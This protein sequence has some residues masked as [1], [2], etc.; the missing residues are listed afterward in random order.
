MGTRAVY[1]FKDSVDSTDRFCVYKH[2]E[3]YPSDSAASLVSA[4]YKTW[5]LPRYEPDEFAAA[6]IAANKHGSGNIRLTNGPENHDDLEFIYE[7]SQAK[8][9]QLIIKAFDVSSFGPSEIFYGRLK[10][11]VGLYGEENTKKKWD[12][13]DNSPHKLLD[14]KTD[15]EYSDYV[16]L[17]K[18]FEGVA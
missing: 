14:K 13:K 2:W 8:N 18:K 5:D 16:R 7:I 12:E 6:F 11:F 15:P 10:D 3:G 17:K 1:V 4:L 9:G